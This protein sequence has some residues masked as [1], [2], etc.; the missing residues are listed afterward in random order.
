MSE[1]WYEDETGPMVRPYTVTRGRTRPDVE[2]S[3][4]L[5]AHVAAVDPAGGEPRLDHA[6]ASLLDLVRRS[7]RPVAEV[8]AD[9]DLPLTVVRILLADLVDAGLV[10]VSAPI[11]R[12]GLD[13]PVL[14]R[15]IADRLR[16]L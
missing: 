1:T 3:L 14:L 8:A 2:H 10:R 13:D 16:E 6:R 7:P 9:A 15:E 11:A 12:Q 5:M 4:D